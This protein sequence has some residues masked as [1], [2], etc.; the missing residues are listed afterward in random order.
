VK[1]V[2][3]GR[4]VDDREQD[5][6]LRPGWVSECYVRLGVVSVVGVGGRVGS[7]GSETHVAIEIRCA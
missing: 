6:W 5:E 4:E 7:K 1:T 2:G 3:G